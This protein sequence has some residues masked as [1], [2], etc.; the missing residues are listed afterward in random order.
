MGAGEAHRWEPR[1]T[2][3]VAGLALSCRRREASE[4]E[5]GHTRITRSSVACAPGRAPAPGR[6]ALARLTME[7]R[8]V[9]PST[10]N[11]LST[12]E[13][14][15]FLQ[16]SP[17]TLKRWATAG[18]IRSERTSGGHRRFQRSELD[19]LASGASSAAAHEVWQWTNA[20]L[21]S[22]GQLELQVRMFQL[23]ARLGSWWAVA[24]RLT[25]VPL[26]MHRRREAGEATTL[27]LQHGVERLARV[28]SWAASCIATRHDAPTALLTQVTGQDRELTVAALEPCLA[29]QGWSACWAGPATSAAIEEELECRRP[30]AL[31]IGAYV[32]ADRAALERLVRDLLALP[33]AGTPLA[34]VG[35]G[36]W[37]EDVGRGARLD[38]FQEFRAWIGRVDEVA[39]AAHGSALASPQ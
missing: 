28:F 9:N 31:V 30:D 6:R 17:T 11:T 8:I 4:A 29:E 13:A 36:G 5:F 34:F 1:V 21:G 23:R 12:S 2:D 7:T 38:G 20:L 16:V 32:E 35:P 37:P 26:E 25:S 18:I 33:G 15:R 22:E 14:A 27:Q 10:R 24:D 39:R 19:Q 3:K